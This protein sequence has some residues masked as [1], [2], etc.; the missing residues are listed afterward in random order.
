MNVAFIYIIT[1]FVQPKVNMFWVPFYVIFLIWAF[2]LE[3]IRPKINYVIA[4][5]KLIL[6][7]REMSVT[8]CKN[9]IGLALKLMIGRFGKV[10]QQ[11][12]DTLHF[13]GNTANIDI[14]NIS[15]R[16]RICKG[17]VPP[18]IFRVFIPC[19]PSCSPAHISHGRSR[20][21]Q[22]WCI[23]LTNVYYTSV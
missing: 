23:L 19:V 20:E 15:E 14:D 6:Q 13:I 9:V 16:W 8:L 22:G 12:W 7:N 21:W 18:S 2:L 5:A 17:E 11:F 3:S 4:Q 1:L 10:L